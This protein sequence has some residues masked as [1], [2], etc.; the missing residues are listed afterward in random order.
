[1]W[2]MCV[3]EADRP[4]QY[5]LF[6]PVPIAHWYTA[7]NALKKIPNFQYLHP[8]HFYAPP[9]FIAP[10]VISLLYFSHQLL[11]FSKPPPP[12]TLQSF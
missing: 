8:A 6:L 5:I 9:H 12:H 4:V 1:M 7:M 11:F 10:E 2:I 3:L